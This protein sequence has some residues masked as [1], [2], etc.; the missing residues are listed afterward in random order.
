MDL[1]QLGA[2]EA[3]EKIAIGEIT[4]EE[5]VQSCLDRIASRDED[6]GSWIW[7]EPEAALDQARSADKVLARG[8]GVGPLHGVPVGIKDII[9][10]RDFPTQNG[11]RGHEGRRT[12]QDAMCVSQLRD[13]GAIILGKTVTTELA[14]RT[15]GKTKNPVNPD[16]TPGGSSSGSAAAVRD[17]QVPLALGTQTGGSVI[18]PASFCGIH[19]LKPTFGLVARSGVIVQA[20]WL[21]TVG[22]YG[23]SI[24]DVALITEQMMMRDHADPQAIARSR[25]PLRKIAMSDPP[26]RPKIA[27]M[28]GAK[29]DQADTAAQSALQ[30]FAHGLGADCTEV[31]MPD[32][33]TEAWSN[34]NILQQYGHAK[35][36]GPLADQH[37]DL[38]SESL[39]ESVAR[40]RTMNEAAY[41]EAIVQRDVLAAGLDEIYATYDA[42]L[43]LS[44][45]GPAPKGLDWTGDPVFNAFWTYA[46]TPCVNLPLLEIDGLPMGVQLTGPR[47]A[48]GPLLRT[49][50]WVEQATKAGG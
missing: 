26:N 45:T 1:W 39:R 15:P 2:A 7:L 50:R 30:D 18:R 46:G 12:N 35:H 4:S 22:T 48:D 13:A 44:S 19:A 25:A 17:G 37:G 28:R 34:Q 6:V 33:M 24:E 43:C 38:M 16:H 36:Y 31:D 47:G 9:E 10:T 20:D 42:V 29:W 23:R 40:G 14:V 21:D 49:A 5:L 27:F 3:A 8:H 11:Y 32:W 41:R